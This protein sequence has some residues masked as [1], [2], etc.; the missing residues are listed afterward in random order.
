MIID[1][2]FNGNKNNY[3]LDNTELSNLPL[4]GDLTYLAEQRIR[5][6]YLN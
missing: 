6:L 4:S 3:D 5:N 1:I 2:K